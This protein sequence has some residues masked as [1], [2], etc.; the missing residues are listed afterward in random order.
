MIVNADI[1]TSCSVNCGGNQTTYP[2]SFSNTFDSDTIDLGAA[3]F[4]VNTDRQ[5]VVSHVGSDPLGDS[6]G[7]V[8]TSPAILGR[9][10]PMLYQTARTS[11]SD[12]WYYVVGMSN[13]NY[14]VQ[15]FFAEIVIDLNNGPGR[16]SFNIDIQVCSLKTTNPNTF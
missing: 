14:T 12:L 11:R 8:K 16:R 13:G 1:I 5:W 2:D 9:D 4:H 7:I 15:L 6:P 3:G 10:L